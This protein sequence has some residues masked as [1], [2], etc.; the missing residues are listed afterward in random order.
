MLLPIEDGGTTKYQ[1]DDAVLMEYTFKGMVLNGNIFAWW[2]LY[3]Y[4]ATT[5]DNAKYKQKLEIALRTLIRSLP[6]FKC[7]YWSMYSLDRLIASPFYHN[8]HIA[9]MQAMYQLTGISIFDEYAKIWSRQ[10]KNPICKSLAFVRKAY[11]KIVE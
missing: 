5:N 10:Q 8:L 11:Q 9:Q 3:D 2:G 7:S 6:Q 1:G 4:V